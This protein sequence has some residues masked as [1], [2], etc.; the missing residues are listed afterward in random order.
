MFDYF[1]KSKLYHL[2]STI[3]LGKNYGEL[4]LEGSQVK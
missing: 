2:S 1:N 4:R 3:E